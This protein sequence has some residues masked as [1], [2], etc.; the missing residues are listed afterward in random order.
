MEYPLCRGS[1]SLC[2]QKRIT[3]PDTESHIF[4]L[5]DLYILIYG[6]VHHENPAKH[7]GAY[8]SLSF[9]INESHPKILY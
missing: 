9:N 7:I 3:N 4:L 8:I 5:P 6:V 2:Y 1:N